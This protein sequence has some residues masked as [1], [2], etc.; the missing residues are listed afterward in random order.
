MPKTVK[1][2]PLRFFNIHSVAKFQKTEGRPFG[3]FRKICE[4]QKMRNFDSLIVPK[5]GTLWDSLT[6]VL[7]QNIKQTERRTLWGH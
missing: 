6:F 1:G 2:G 3:V 7:L 5:K 4:K